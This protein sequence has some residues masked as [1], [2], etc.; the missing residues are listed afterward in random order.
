MH[1]FRRRPI[2]IHKKLPV[3]R[4]TKEIN[5]DEDLGT[6]KDGTAVAQNMEAFVV[7]SRA[8][9][10]AR[11]APPT[12]GNG[13]EKWPPSIAPL[14]RGSR[15]SRCVGGMGGSGRVRKGLG[16]RLCRERGAGRGVTVRRLAVV[17]WAGRVA[18]GGAGGGKFGGAGGGGDYR[19]VGMRGMLGRN[20]CG[21]ASRRRGVPLRG[22]AHALP[23]RC[24]SSCRAATGLRSDSAAAGA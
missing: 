1:S 2:D 24:R 3:V 23:A 5:W 12:P 4:S 11:R 7:R 18:V 20:H 13:A 8:P 10:R 15:G 17:G 9:R 6:N 19:R 21:R 14:P 16:R 22:G